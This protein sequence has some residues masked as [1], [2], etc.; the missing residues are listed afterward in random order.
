MLQTEKI[1][2]WS[3][4]LICEKC[5]KLAIANSQLRVIDNNNQESINH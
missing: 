2:F 3:L 5:H 1:A 4:D